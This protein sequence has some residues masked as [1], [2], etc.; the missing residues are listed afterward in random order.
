VT[1][2]GHRRRLSIVARRPTATNR[3]LLNAFETLG[4]ETRHLDPS[5]R[6]DEALDGDVVL[7]R[8]DV[9]PALDGVDGGLWTLRRLEHEPV[10]V[11]NPPAALLAAHD[12]LATSVALR[13][14]GLPHPRTAL[15]DEE[16][17]MPAF[18]PPVVVKPRFGSWGRDV[19]RCADASELTGLLARLRDRPWFR[20]HGALVQ[21]L[22]PTRGED[23]RVVVAGDAAIGAVRRVAPPGEWRTNVALGATRHPTVAP[24]EAAAL[25]LA[26]ADAIGADL[27]GVDL[28]PLPGGGWVVLEINGAVDFTDD[29]SP[30]GG[31]VFALA[32][33]QLAA[34]AAAAT[35]DDEPVVG[36]RT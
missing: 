27:V 2:S 24:P 15:V 10:H 21:E 6:A 1:R 8:V 36:A 30:P 16:S 29:Y 13:R 31:D 33:R 12:K 3:L 25:A 20:R 4:W 19:E 35:V 23:L 22:V 28:L 9:A 26:A 11:L 32:A 17:P 14:A 34:A 7:A 18:V 5:A